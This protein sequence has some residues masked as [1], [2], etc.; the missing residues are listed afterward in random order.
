MLRVSAT[1]RSGET[2]I[3]P[4]STNRFSSSYPPPL[5]LFPRFNVCGTVAKP[6]APLNTPK[7]AQLLP[8]PHSHGVAIQFIDDPDGPS[9]AENPNN[10]AV[11]DVDTCDLATNP[12]CGPQ[13][14][15]ATPNAGAA[16][17]NPSAVARCVQ[18]PGRTECSPQP[19]TVTDNA[20]IISYYDGQPPVF[21]LQDETNP[22]GGIVLTY[23][24][25]TAY[26]NEPF[27]CGGTDPATG[28]APLRSLFVFLP[29]LTQS[30]P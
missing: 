22:Q 24:G 13:N 2:P 5:P 16:E 21:A 17:N 11:V 18:N 28:S 27:P 14:Y 15:P 4:P 29:L 12:Q 23:L 8:I 3:G 30:S 1:R 20:E 10:V 7:T 19:A 26:L 6:I 9:A 25:A